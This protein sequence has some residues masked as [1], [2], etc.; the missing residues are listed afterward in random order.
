LTERLCRLAPFCPCLG[1]QAIRNCLIAALRYFSRHKRYSFI[2]IAGLMVGPAC[3]IF[4]ILFVQDELSYDKWI[5]GQKIS[6][7]S[8]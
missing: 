2:N 8:G 7:V 6:I 3:A 5:P 1:D 4:I